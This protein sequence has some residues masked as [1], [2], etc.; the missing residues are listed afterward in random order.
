MELL[1]PTI[2]E[3]MTFVPKTV[4]IMFCSMILTYFIIKL[5]FFTYL[6]KLSRPVTSFL[7]LPEAASATSVIAFGSVLSS[8]M[9]LSEF[10]KNDIINEQ[11]TYMGA[12]LNGVSL[13]VKEIFTYQIPV[14]I[15]IL[16]LKAGLIYCV[17]FS[18]T[19]VLKY[20]YIFFYIRFKNKKNTP[21]TRSTQST[22]HDPQISIVLS[23]QISSFLKM[24]SVYVSVTF[25]ILFACNSGMLVVFEKLVAPINRLL[26]LPMV[27]AVP[28]SIF[29]FSPIAGASAVG[30]LIT[31]N[32]ISEIDAVLAVIVGS[33]MLIPIYTLRGSLSRSIAIFGPKLG[34]KIVLTSTALAMLS[35]FIFLII[36]LL[37]KGV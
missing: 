26:S 5:G 6:Y 3:M 9:M 20:F 13:N 11:D 27:L 14:I 15:P 7:H 12:L 33:L 10:H 19:A 28:I 34:I 25:I 30:T 32:T 23:S 21:A 2:N 35:R 18:F 24:I 4:L 29:V 17:C 31:S 8:N 37:Y 16:G 1:L 22:N 36:L